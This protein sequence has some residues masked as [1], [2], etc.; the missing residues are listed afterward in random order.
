LAQRAFVGPWKKSFIPI[1][2]KK[3]SLDEIEHGMLRKNYVEPRIHFGVN[4]ASVS[5]PPLR[6]EAFVGSRLGRQLDEQAKLFFSNES[7]NRFDPVKKSL[8]LNPI[9]KWFNGDFSKSGDAGTVAYVAKYLPRLNEALSAGG[10]KPGD[11]SVE[12]GDYNWNL[13]GK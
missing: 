4:C 12:Y 7:E 3:L 13:N 10:L 8:R 9:L 6:A 11:I 5:C 1:F 2:G